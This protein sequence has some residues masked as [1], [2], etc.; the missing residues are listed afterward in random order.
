[1]PTYI[2]HRRWRHYNFQFS[3]FHFQLIYFS[4][5]K[6][7]FDL[8]TLISNVTVVTM[9]EK[10]DVLFGAYIAVTDGKIS[11]IGK[12]LPEGQ[13]STIVDGTGMV[14][15]P[16]LV[17]CHTHLAS[18]VLRSYVDDAT[19]GEAL[20][21]QLQKE[22][23]LDRRSAKASALLGIAECL[24]FGITSVSDLYY[25]PDAT[26]E[27]L[28]ETGMKGNVALSSYRFIDESEDFDF[29]T[30]EQ[31]R[32][33]VKVKDKWHGYEDGRVRVDG[34]IW[35]E[36]ISNHKLWEGIADY[37][38]EEGLGVQ[39]HLAA[40]EAEA[41]DCL[42]RTGLSPAELL[43]CH[44][45]LNVPVTAAGCAALTE[46]D[47]AVLGKKKATA[48]VTPCANAKAGIP[49]APIAS[50]VK[51]GINVALGTDGA[52]EAGN[53]DMFEV[54]RQAAYG[55]RMAAGDP[56]KFPAPAVLMMATVCGARAQGRSQETGM[57]KEGFDADIVLV[58]FTAPHLMPCHNV[59]SSL[60][61]SAKGGDVAMT[62]VRGRI[63]YQSG[64]FPTIDL[65]EVVE[66]I[67]GYAIPKLLEDNK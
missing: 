41:E 32:E 65:P 22:S 27:A 43:N 20:T 46:E 17:N 38:A 58:D 56:A 2:N 51:A 39:M 57:L 66:E 28:A 21:Q 9:N 31:C 3:I 45:L 1:M 18:T 19:R 64:R 34:G 16:G 11:Y 33:F 29:E 15:M 26:A 47:K 49:L 63:L 24:R 36:Y 10:M 60:V 6:G 59:I 35:A 14:A 13:P 42:D 54:M 37:C 55:E 53:L 62:M 50:T 12:T 40:A 61:F 4:L 48:V 67:T 52:V 5:Q 25:Y 7:S 8:D 23:R 30:D 44:R